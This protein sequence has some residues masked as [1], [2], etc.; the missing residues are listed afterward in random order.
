MVFQGCG[1][2]FGE[3]EG[4]GHEL[5]KVSPQFKIATSVPS[6]FAVCTG[7]IPNNLDTRIVLK[8]KNDHTKPT[9]PHTPNKN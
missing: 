4:E 3:V 9:P 1:G 5:F 8:F 2:A 6:W 7:I